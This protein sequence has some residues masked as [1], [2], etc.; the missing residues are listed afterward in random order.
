V[1]L[2]EDLLELAKKSVNYNRSDVLDARLR[3]AISTGYYALFHLLLEHGAAR[4]IRHIGLQ[5]LVSRA[6]VHNDMQRAAKSF[7]SGSGGLPKHITNAFGTAI[8]P[9]PAQIMTVASAFVELQRAR[10]EADYNRAISFSRA[11][12]RKL[13]EKAEKAFTEWK[14]VVAMPAHTE[15]C[16][17]FLA[18]LLLDERW[19]K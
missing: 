19:K 4:I 14:A 13:V 2:A 11:E 8:P 18:S 17:L 6:Y 10:H 16:E 5:Q 7:L 9:V 3:R 1:S 12:A 15:M